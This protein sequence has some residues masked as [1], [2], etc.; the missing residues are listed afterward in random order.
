MMPSSIHGKRL[1]TSIANLTKAIRHPELILWRFNDIFLSD[2]FG[3]R[4]RKEF[5]VHKNGKQMLFRVT[6]RGKLRK[7]ANKK[8]NL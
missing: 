1:F 3:F 5:V 6:W 8:K 7:A 4:C 2:Y